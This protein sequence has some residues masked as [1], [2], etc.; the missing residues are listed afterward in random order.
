MFL[1]GTQLL[2]D[3]VSLEMSVFYVVITVYLLISS[4][5]ALGADFALTSCYGFCGVRTIAN[6]RRICCE[7]GL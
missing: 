7:G 3:L 2:V 5:C 6:L 1:F 4:P